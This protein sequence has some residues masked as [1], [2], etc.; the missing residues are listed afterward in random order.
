MSRRGRRFSSAIVAA[1]LVVAAV[2]SFTGSPSDARSDLQPHA[3]SHLP[4]ELLDAYGLLRRA[5]RAS[6]RPP[7]P[8][9]QGSEPAL[10]RRASVKAGGAMYFIPGAT[11]ACL[12]ITRS[13]G[14]G[15]GCA[16]LQSV[17]RVGIAIGSAG[18]QGG[19]RLDGVAPDHIRALRIV[20][21]EGPALVVEVIENAYAIDYPGLAR[22][23][24]YLDA[25]GS[26]VEAVQIEEAG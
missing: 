17:L 2:G 22:T 4:R 7:V 16:A 26:V 11:G 15:T 23:F 1:A 6:D 19:R 18:T 3:A 10:A 13:G 20:R 14:S 8:A 24:E 9:S 5:A 25:N 21:H 12:T